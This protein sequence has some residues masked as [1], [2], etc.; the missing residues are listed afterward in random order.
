MPAWPLAMQTWPRPGRRGHDRADV[1]DDVEAGDEADAD[2][3]DADDR[4]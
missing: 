2:A 4:H 3:H 1:A